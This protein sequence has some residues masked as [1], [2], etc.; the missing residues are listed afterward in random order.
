[1]AGYL[2]TVKSDIAFN[3]DFMCEVALPNKEIA[4]VY[5]KEIP[6]RLEEMIQL[7]LN[8]PETNI[9]DKAP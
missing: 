6:Q 3:G 9:S 7:S 5:N 4:F 2:K 1:M 8:P